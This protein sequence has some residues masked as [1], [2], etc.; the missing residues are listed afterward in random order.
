[1]NEL[2][3]FERVL[4][5]SREKAIRKHVMAYSKVL[6]FDRKGRE[7][8]MTDCWVNIMPPT[9]YRTLAPSSS[10]VGFRKRDLLHVATPGGCSD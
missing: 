2:H 8:R 4:A 7:I 6:E 5:Q 9:H 3:R 10:S 1:M